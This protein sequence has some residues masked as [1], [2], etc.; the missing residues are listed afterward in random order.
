VGADCDAGFNFTDVVISEVA[1]DGMI[2]IFNG[3]AA[4]IDVSNYWL[5]NRPTYQ[6]LSA[7]TLECGDLLLQPGEVV[8]VSGFSGF[9]ATDAE[10][11]LYSSS[12]FGS[13]DAIVGYLE[14]GSAGHGRAGVAIEAGIWEADFFLNAPT[15][16]QSLQFGTN[17]DNEIE[18]TMAAP[19]L[20]EVNSFTTTTDNDDVSVSLS[21]FPNP[22]QGD[23]LNIEVE[24]MIGEF[25]QVQVYNINGTQLMSTLM[26]VSSSTTTIHLPIGPAGTYFLRVVN[27][28]QVV[29]ERFSRF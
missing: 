7:M 12:S 5:C 6:R 28:G 16:G 15:T 29:T 27:N 18:W 20:C 11:G 23:E 10:L 17:D 14:W 26:P 24:G 25:M 3:T 4:A 13:S 1:S 22:I 2:E 21:V 9:D 8:V 19:S